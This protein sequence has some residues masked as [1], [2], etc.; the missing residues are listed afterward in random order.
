MKTSDCYCV[1]TRIDGKQRDAS[2][3]LSVCK[4]HAVEV[5]VIDARLRRQGARTVRFRSGTANTK[6]K[7]GNAQSF[8]FSIPSFG[9]L[10]IGGIRA[11]A[12]WLVSGR[13]R[14]SALR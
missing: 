4:V 11:E 2:R 6:A 8:I 5:A 7:R 10:V 3:L 9:F 1:V 12:A 14:P 13:Q